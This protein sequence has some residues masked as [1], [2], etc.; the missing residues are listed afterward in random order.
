VI[1]RAGE[2]SKGFEY[3]KYR[4]S[5]AVATMDGLKFRQH[6]FEL[7]PGDVLFVYTD[8]VLEATNAKEELYGE[9]RLLEV[10][11]KNEGESLENLLH[12]IRADIDGFVG[13][14]PQFDDIT[15]LGFE[16]YGKGKEN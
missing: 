14:A 4:H 8:G 7:N 13:E 10:M 6:E 11:N 5:P 9:D 16:Y 12:S 1:K 2:E 15:M 3:V